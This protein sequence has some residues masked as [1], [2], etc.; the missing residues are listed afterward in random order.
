MNVAGVQSSPHVAVSTVIVS[1]HLI[2]V[3]AA[4][5]EI[6]EGGCSYYYQQTLHLNRETHGLS[7]APRLPILQTQSHKGM[8]EDVPILIEC[9]RDMD[10]VERRLKRGL[11]TIVMTE[12]WFKSPIGF[13]RL[14]HPRFFRMSWRFI[15][16]L[17]NKNCYYYGIGVDALQDIARLCEF[18]SGN[19]RVLFSKVRLCVKK[20][21]CGIVSPV[22]G[23]T[24][25]WYHDKLRL[26]GYF[27]A[28]STQCVNRLSDIPNH[29]PIRIL[30]V[31]RMLDWKRVDTIIKA[32]G[33]LNQPRR[34]HLT[35]VGDGPERMKLE[36]MA[37]GVE[38]VEFRDFVA[39]EEVRRLM[40]EHDVFVL[41]SNEEEGWGATVS[42]A[43]EEGM[44]IYGTFEA[45][46]T[47]SMLPDCRLYHA[48]D[49]HML[50]KLLSQP[51]CYCE[52]GSWSV[53]GAAI[54][55]KCW[56]EDVGMKD[57]KSYYGIRTSNG[58]RIERRV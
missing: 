32:V 11:K 51:V 57:V 46:S 43:M 52:I 22:D 27:V 18:F 21:P 14:L 35:L 1:S 30:W 31:G 12:R 44:C 10:L 50:A 8:L 38:G 33:L 24:F 49:Y 4:F 58:V 9:M 28:P 20:V 54:A 6:W 26:W 7:A 47:Q 56:M 42:E 25:R 5:D 34:Y 39:L 36:R 55:L 37:L 45:G 53:T 19:F 17:R 3:F 2:P 23:R 13:A 15:R 41:S 29:R 16:A 40:R 48:G